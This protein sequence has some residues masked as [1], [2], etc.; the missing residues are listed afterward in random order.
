MAKPATL[1]AEGSAS[2]TPTPNHLTKRP[3]K[4]HWMMTVRTFTARS[5]CAKNAV[6]VVLVEK[7]CGAEFGLLKV[8]NRQC[9]RV[10]QHVPAD[11]Q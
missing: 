4:K 8:Q 2:V 9:Y 11:A 10:Q 6:R 7:W 3:V 5:S 1:I